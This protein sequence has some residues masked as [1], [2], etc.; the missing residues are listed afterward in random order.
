MFV[1]NFVNNFAT[2]S[3]VSSNTDVPF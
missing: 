1:D 3:N 2:R